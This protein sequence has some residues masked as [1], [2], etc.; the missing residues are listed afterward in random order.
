M[1]I[2]FMSNRAMPAFLP[3]LILLG[4]FALVLAVLLP[5]PPLRPAT[6]TT[7]TTLPPTAVAVVPTD[8]PP[9]EVVAAYSPAAVSE[10][11]GV[12]G[13][14]CSACHGLDARGIPGLGKNL[15]ESEFVHAMTDEQLLSFIIAGRD[16]SN[17]LNT[18][19][20]PMPARGGNPS[21]TDEQLRSVIAYLRSQS[22]GT[23]M[24][25]VVQAAP[26]TAPTVRLAEPILPTAIPVT[27]QPFTAAAAYMWACAGCHG[28]N[29][30]GSAPFGPGFETSPLLAD[31]AALLAFLIEGTPLA[32]P[33]VEYPHP[34]Q[35]GYPM[36]TD[37]QL[38]ELTDYLYS[39]VGSNL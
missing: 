30:K 24:V 29:G 18:T 38:S 19:G 20:V 11:Q 14:I 7:P 12:F 36:L 37:E 31:R 35:G 33:R 13:S 5:T 21:L 32:D 2:N 17:P 26:T 9:T 34:A 3:A 25:T 1:R 8:L 28:T 27:P 39:L 23:Q 15:I 10:G 22:T 6:P 16:A 4:V